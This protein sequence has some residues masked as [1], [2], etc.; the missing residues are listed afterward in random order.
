MDRHH[1]LNLTEAA[2]AFIDAGLEATDPS[3][4]ATA[5]VQRE[6]VHRGMLDLWC[7]MTGMTGDGDRDLAARLLISHV[8]VPTYA[9]MVVGR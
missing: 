6:L 8:E 2:R 7:A 1:D 5:R 3:I 4:P 9:D